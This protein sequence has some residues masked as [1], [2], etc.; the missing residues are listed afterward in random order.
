MPGVYTC[1]SIVRIGSKKDTFAVFSVLV[2]IRAL[3]TI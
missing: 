2:T 3:D 1:H